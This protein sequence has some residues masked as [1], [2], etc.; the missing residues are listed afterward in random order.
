MRLKLKES[1]DLKLKYEE[2]R[3]ILITSISHD[4]KTLLLQ[5]KVMLKV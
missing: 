1:V 4:L 3:K 5:L 2:N